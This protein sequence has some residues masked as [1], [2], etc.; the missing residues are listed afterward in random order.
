MTLGRITLEAIVKTFLQRGKPCAD[1]TRDTIRAPACSVRKL[2]LCGLKDF[3]QFVRHID[4]RVMSARK[5]PY[6]PAGIGFGTFEGLFEGR[7][8][9]AGGADVIATLAMSS[10]TS[11]CGQFC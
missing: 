1:P 4:H 6:D 3:G 9:K 5:F 8:G 11:V 10:A 7:G 2:L